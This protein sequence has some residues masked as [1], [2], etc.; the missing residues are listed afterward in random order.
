MIHIHILP[1]VV[2]LRPF[3]HSYYYHHNQLS[4]STDAI[5]CEIGAEKKHSC[6]S[7]TPQPLDYRRLLVQMEETER[8]FDEYFRQHLVKLKQCLELRCFEQDFR[9]LQVG[10]SFL[11]LFINLNNLITL[12]HSLSVQLRRPSAH[13]VRD[14]LRWKYRGPGGLFDQGGETV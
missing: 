2:S 1:V 5:K 12:S 9:E 11:I 7:K 3:N 8:R 10:D 6:L 4:C 14:D 13:L